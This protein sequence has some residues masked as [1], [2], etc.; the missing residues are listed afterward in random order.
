MDNI[1]SGFPGGSAVKISP[2]NAG[3]IQVPS[4]GKEDPLEKEMSIHS[5]ILDWINPWTEET[6]RL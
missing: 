3:K 5:S 4:P 6:G 1:F 2:A